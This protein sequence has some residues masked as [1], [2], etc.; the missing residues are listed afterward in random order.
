MGTRL[1]FRIC[2]RILVPCSS[3]LFLI[4]SG[5]PTARTLHSLKSVRRGTYNREV[6]FL[7]RRPT[8]GSYEYFSCRDSLVMGAYCNPDNSPEN[9]IHSRKGNSTS[10]SSEQKSPSNEPSLI[11]SMLN[12]ALTVEASLVSPDIFRQEIALMSGRDLA[13]AMYLSSKVHI[14]I[15]CRPN[16]KLSYSSTS[17]TSF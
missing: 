13:E 8:A 14:T 5:M 3:F 9:L 10:S 15:L 2:M 7:R 11:I 16:I 4:I 12:K 1:L 17:L 6:L